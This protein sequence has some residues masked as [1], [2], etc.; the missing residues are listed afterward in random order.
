MSDIK[1]VINPKEFYEAID[2]IMWEYDLR[3]LEAIVAYCEK[4]LIEIEAVIPLVKKNE[5]FRSQLQL[6]GEALNILEKR[7]RLPL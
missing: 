6:D 3:L 2:F 4:D 7:A 5:H 1:S